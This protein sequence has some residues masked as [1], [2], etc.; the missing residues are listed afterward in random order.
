MRVTHKNSRLTDAFDPGTL[1]LVWLIAQR[2]DGV[3]GMGD[4]SFV[5]GMAAVAM[6]R[7]PATEQTKRL[8]AIARRIGVRNEI[9]GLIAFL[10]AEA[11]RGIAWRVRALPARG[12]RR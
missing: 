5:R 1:V 7:S 11:E 4:L 8:S 2:S 9:E 12:R 3:L 6:T 10:Y